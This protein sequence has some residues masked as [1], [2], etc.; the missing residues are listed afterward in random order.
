M[1]EIDVAC[2][3]S[4][5]LSPNV[6]I[7]YVMYDRNNLMFPHVMLYATKNIPPMRERSIYYG[8]ADEWTGKLSICM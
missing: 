2:Y 6:F 3:M 8:V 7:R 4:H 1:K 5:S